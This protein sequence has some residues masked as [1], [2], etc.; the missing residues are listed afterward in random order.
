MRPALI[1]RHQNLKLYIEAEG[2][3]LAEEE[4]LEKFIN[5]IVMV[6]WV[7]PPLYS[8]QL[9]GTDECVLLNA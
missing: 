4:W 7:H 8:T 2:K 1:E 6:F 3:M 5:E 9:L